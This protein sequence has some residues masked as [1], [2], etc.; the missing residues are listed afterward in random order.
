M[1]QLTQSEK[2]SLSTTEIS[3]RLREQL[4]KEFQNCKFSVRSEYYSMGSSISV[5][6]ME[7]DFDVVK[8][9]SD[10]DED[11][12]NR[13]IDDYRTEEHIKTMQESGYCQLNSYTLRDNFN[14][15]VWC[16]G[17]FLTEAGHKLLKRVVEIADQYNYDNSDSMTDY[18]DVNFSFRMEIGKWDKHFERVI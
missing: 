17:V 15:D 6:L 1:I 4:K 3:R 5:S 9:F 7:A 2:I 11:V 10:I 18:Y 13:Y 14:P 16:N 12:K 8:N